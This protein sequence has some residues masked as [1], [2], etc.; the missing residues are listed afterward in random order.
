[1]ISQENITLRENASLDTI[2]LAPFSAEEI[3]QHLPFSNEY[4]QFNPVRTGSEQTAE[5]IVRS[6]EE[7][8]H[9]LTWGIYTGSKS[10]ANFIGTVAVSEVNAGTAE[11]PL[12]SKAMQ[13]VHTGIFSGERHGQGIGTLAKLAVISYAFEKHNTH[14]VYAHAS[15]SNIAAHRS[16]TKV[17]L[18][19]LDT[20]K[21]Y[22]FADGSMTTFWM[23]ADPLAQAN[24]P[25]DQAVLAKGWDRYLT[26]QQNLTITYREKD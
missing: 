1:M 8:E 21:Y 4:T 19:Q 15:S 11:E 20:Y 13:E 3:E 9:Y 26:A 14:A 5:E 18:S 7:L 25:K 17:G 24:Q 6:Q 10:T 23:I 16:L 12:W 22:D 2:E